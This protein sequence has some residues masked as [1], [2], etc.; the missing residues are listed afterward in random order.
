MNALSVSGLLKA[1]GAQPILQAL[2]II[3]GTFILEDAA[4][5]LTAMQVQDGS[6]RPV[7]ALVALYAGIVLGDLGLYGLGRLATLSSWIRGRLPP[8]KRQRSRAWIEKHVFRIVFVS[9]FVPGARLP[10]YTTCG[11]LE[12]S[13]L[14]FALAAIC[15]TSIWTTA[16]FLVSLH[17]GKFLMDHFGAWR[18]FG[19]AGFIA[20]IL[21]I[22]RLVARLQE[23]GR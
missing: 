16:L 5:V 22:S 1:A 4:T 13:L 23:P 19:A 14:R 18:W 17:V 11:Y 8:D 6:V 3:A 7:V 20:I 9:R 12:A 10:T 15:A 2:A 21:L